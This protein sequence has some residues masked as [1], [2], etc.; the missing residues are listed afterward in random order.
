MWLPL[1]AF[2]YFFSISISYVLIWREKKNSHRYTY[3]RTFDRIQIWNPNYKIKTEI[4]TFQNPIQKKLIFHS[5][6]L[7]LF[8]SSISLGIDDIKFFTLFHRLLPTFICILRVPKMKRKKT[9]NSKRFSVYILNDEMWWSN[10]FFSSSSQ[11]QMCFFYFAYFFGIHCFENGSLFYLSWTRCLHNWKLLRNVLKITI[12]IRSIQW[13]TAYNVC[14]ARIYSAHHIVPY[15]I[16]D[17]SFL[18]VV[19]KPYSQNNGC[20]AKQT[21][22]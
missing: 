19:E 17:I 13:T 2:L 20:N 1:P 18:R 21:S 16:S 3:T 14:Q 6:F 10:T 9:H 15:H 8:L 11:I 7:S 22:E 4:L 12:K 5:L